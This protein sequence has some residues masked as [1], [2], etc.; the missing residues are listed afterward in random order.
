[1]P[2]KHENKMV[3]RF[4]LTLPDRII[5][6]LQYI[7]FGG[8]LIQQCVDLRWLIPGKISQDGRKSANIFVRVSQA[9]NI[10]ISVLTD[11]DENGFVVFPIGR[12]TGQDQTQAK[13]ED[14]F[15][16]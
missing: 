1:M 13:Q 16:E 9:I 8:L 15:Q 5:D 12:S 6:N 4:F 7:L 11:A 14:M 10:G 3:D 2:G